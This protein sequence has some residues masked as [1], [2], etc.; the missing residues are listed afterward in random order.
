MQA[1]FWAR[2]IVAILLG[3]AVAKIKPLNTDLPRPPPLD[4]CKLNAYILS[5][6]LQM[7]VLVVIAFAICWAHN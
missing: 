2:N 7:M 3:Q 4:H 1:N 6:V 5:Q